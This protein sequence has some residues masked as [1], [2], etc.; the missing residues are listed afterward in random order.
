LRLFRA[1]Y[2]KH[3]DTLAVDSEPGVVS[4]YRVPL[5]FAQEVMKAL[6]KGS[7][8]IGPSGL[9]GSRFT[10]WQLY[11]LAAGGSRERFQAW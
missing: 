10:R 8:S 11:R 1:I 4:G 2:R 7:V 5:V 9:E 6:R 3:R